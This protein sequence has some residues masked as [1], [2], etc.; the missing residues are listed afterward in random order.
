[1][2]TLSRII[3]SP[4]LAYAITLDMK[5]VALGGCLLCGFS[6]FLDGYIAKNYNQKTVLGAFLDPSK[7]NMKTG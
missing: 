4:F 5:E 1:M 7:Y 3:A 2:I 6:D